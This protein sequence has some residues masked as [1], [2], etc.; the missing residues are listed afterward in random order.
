M[1]EKQDTYDREGTITV[2]SWSPD[3]TRSA[4]SPTP[5]PAGTLLQR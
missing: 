3:S 2:N 4:A 1:P 5:A